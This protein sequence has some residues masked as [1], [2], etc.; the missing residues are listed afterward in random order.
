MKAVFAIDPG[1]H[2]GWAYFLDGK[3]VDSGYCSKRAFLSGILS[4][5]ES[6]AG[7]KLPPSDISP[8]SVLI[9]EMPT[10]RGRQGENKGTPDT[11]IALGV[12]LG[13]AVGL[14]MRK[15]EVV[16]FVTPN[17]WKGSVPKDICHRRIEK[18]LDEDEQLP[19]NHNAKD[20]V[21]VG[22]WKLGRYRR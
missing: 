21:G 17:E 12:T 3:L 13:Q 19:D 2:M 16:E 6:R 1:K 5:A 4:R 8:V 10:Y 14:Y 20:A 18:V 11:L 9:G 15:V 7:Q 22:L